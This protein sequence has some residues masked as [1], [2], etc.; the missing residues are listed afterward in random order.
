MDGLEGVCNY[1]GVQ[2]KRRTPIIQGEIS[3]C[4]L[5]STTRVELLHDNTRNDSQKEI[6]LKYFTDGMTSKGLISKINV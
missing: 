1:Y 2:K 6:P 4:I 3:H 5:T